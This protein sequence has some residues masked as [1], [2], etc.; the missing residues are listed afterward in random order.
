[1]AA[2]I[3]HLSKAAKNTK[4]KEATYGKVASVILQLPVAAEAEMVSGDENEAPI[5]L[6]ILIIESGMN[7]GTHTG[8]ISS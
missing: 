6:A 7:P 1:M 4:T 3:V 5:E 2:A 8:G